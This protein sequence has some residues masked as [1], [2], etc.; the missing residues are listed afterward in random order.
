M[1]AQ[2][3]QGIRSDVESGTCF[4]TLVALDP[5]EGLDVDRARRVSDCGDQKAAGDTGADDANSQFSLPRKRAD[6]NC[7]QLEPNA[8]TP[9]RY[10]LRIKFIYAN[11]S[12]LKR[13]GD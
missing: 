8:V 10:T 13:S 3:F 2:R 4:V 6:R 7:E 5:V 1:E 11:Q 12:G 9:A